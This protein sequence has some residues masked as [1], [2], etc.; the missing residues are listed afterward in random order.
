MGARAE[1]GRLSPE[2]RAVV[3]DQVQVER[4]TGVGQAAD[5]LR[6]AP[7]GGDDRFR[8]DLVELQVLH[9]AA[10]CFAVR[11]IVAEKRRVLPLVALLIRPP[12]VG[13][14]QIVTDRPCAEYGLG[15]RR[16]RGRRGRSGRL[17]VERSGKQRQSGERGGG[18]SSGRGEALR[19]HDRTPWREGSDAQG[20]G[21]ACI[22]P[23]AWA[24]CKSCMTRGSADGHLLSA[25][26]RLSGFMSKPRHGFFSPEM[27]EAR[28]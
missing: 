13:T 11:S 12:A 22:I 4:I 16:F 15:D 6:P 24:A 14:E 20:G 23:S 9:D 25:L 21:M 19:S 26:C 27:P 7:A 10:P 5:A 18:I 1:V 3:V 8:P 17:S 28:A 2:R